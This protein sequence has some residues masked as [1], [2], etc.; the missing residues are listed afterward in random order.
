MAM[1][2]TCLGWLRVLQSWVLQSFMRRKGP[3]SSISM[4][5]RKSRAQ[6]SKRPWRV[7]DLDALAGRWFSHAGLTGQTGTGE[8]LRPVATAFGQGKGRYRWLGTGVE[9]KAELAP[10]GFAKQGASLSRVAPT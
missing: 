3:T 5:C 7:D 8:G 2:P 9:S 6:L 4:P 10:R 1:K